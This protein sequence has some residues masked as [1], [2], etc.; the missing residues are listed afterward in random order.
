MAKSN[1]LEL[2][3]YISSVVK[4]DPPRLNAINAGMAYSQGGG[5][6]DM[7]KLSLGDPGANSLIFDPSK[8]G[9]PNLGRSHPPKGKIF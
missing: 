3:S 4:S 6:L 2:S 8:A 9:G 1:L 7:N 5:D